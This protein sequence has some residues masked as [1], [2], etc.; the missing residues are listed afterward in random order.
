MFA[1][2]YV[3]I[4]N[5]CNR[6][7]S[8]CPGTRRPPRRLSAAEFSGIIRQV[9][10]LTRFLYLHVMGEPLS[11]PELGTFLDLAGE[12][13][14][15]VILTT[16]GTLLPRT[17]EDLLGK[18]ALHKVNV[19][20]HSFEANEYPQTLEAYLDGCF[21][22][23]RQAAERGILCSFRLWNL[24][25]EKTRGQNRCNGQ[26]LS[27]LGDWFPE[28]WQENSRGYRLAPGAFLEWGEKFQWP[29]LAAKD[30]GEAGFCRGLRDQFAILSDGRVVPCCLDG[31][32]ILSLGNVFSRPLE[33]ILASDRAKKIY[34]GFSGRR[35]E[36]PL[37]RR[38]GYAQRFTKET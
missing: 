16:N 32:G 31:E 7:C 20:L 14:F 28:P 24:D 2:A 5:S 15:R 11:H 23:G 4:T 34:D 30:L 21:S 35:R 3:E 18:K 19:S 1:K 8:F 17:G 33:E 22:F 12:L 38:C 13:D 27:R 29:D 9:R 26:I 6:Q 25:G 10:P 37:C 36:E